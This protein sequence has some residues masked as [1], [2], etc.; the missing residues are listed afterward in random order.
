ME[1]S[2]H[3]HPLQW[4]LVYLTWNMLGQSFCI[5]RTLTSNKH[6][7]EAFDFRDETSFTE[8]YEASVPSFLQSVN[9]FIHHPAGLEWEMSTDVEFPQVQIQH[10]WL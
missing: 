10:L 7:S 3:L 1:Y 4:K 8:T 5:S 9:V 6:L 2:P